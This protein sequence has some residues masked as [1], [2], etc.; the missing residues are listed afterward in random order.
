MNLFKKILAFCIICW[1]YGSV[2]LLG[3]IY[4]NKENFETA[5]IIGFL[6]L[7]IILRQVLN[8]VLRKKRSTLPVL[9]V[10]IIYSFNCL[11][12]LIKFEILI[13]FFNLLLG[14]IVT[15]S[16]LIVINTSFYDAIKDSKLELKNLI[17]IN[18]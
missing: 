3:I 5:G 8:I 11:L 2:A 1:T 12:F 6:I 17:K 10:S 15:R 7:S 13:A 4:L 18:L 16:M 14:Y 9:Y